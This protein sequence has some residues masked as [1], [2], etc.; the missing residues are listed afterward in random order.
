MNTFL[1]NR[2][3]EPKFC[4]SIAAPN[5]SKLKSSVKSAF[6]SGANF[7]EIRLD[8]IDSF[9]IDSIEQLS[10]LHKNK[11]I[12]TFRSKHQGGFS[13]IS[14][15]DRVKILI[16]LLDLKHSMKDVESDTFNRNSSLFKNEKNLIV[17]WHNFKS[18]PSTKS[19]STMIKKISK[20]LTTTSQIIKIVTYANSLNDCNKVYR[21]Y[22]QF[23]KSKFQL[24]AFCMGETG[25]IS[26]ILSPMLGAP[27]IYCSSGNKAI[28]PGQ[29]SINTLKE[30]YSNF[31]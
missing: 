13:N 4:V 2:T 20:K 26:R 18:T 8:S 29:I 9:S 5:T 22:P 11:L 3:Q 28:A 19:L 31:S 1:K 14:E 16:Q 30:I 21:L 6:S 23:E 12:L 15:P 7:V 24:L 27:F 10:N 25:S 17:S